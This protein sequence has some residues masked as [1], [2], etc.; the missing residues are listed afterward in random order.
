MRH[1]IAYKIP[2]TAGNKMTKI[3][4]TKALVR[5]LDVEKRSAI[6]IIMMTTQIT[7]NGTHA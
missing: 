4:Q 7:I 1:L 5:D 3:D 2:E 6:M